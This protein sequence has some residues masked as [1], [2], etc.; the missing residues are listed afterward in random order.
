MPADIVQIQLNS[1]LKD[2]VDTMILGTGL[3]AVENGNQVDLIDHNGK[4]WGAVTNAGDGR[5]KYF[6]SVMGDE[7]TA[8]LDSITNYIH[9]DYEESWEFNEVP[10]GEFADSIA[11]VDSDDLRKALT[12]SFLET[13]R[14]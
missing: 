10:P 8:D 6:S 12:D 2:A 5:Y 9:D 13:H 4:K 14:K 1:A 3:K 11:K 7:V